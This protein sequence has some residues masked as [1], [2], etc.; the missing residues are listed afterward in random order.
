MPPLLRLEEPRERELVLRIELE[1]DRLDEVD[2]R[3]EPDER[4]L[5]DEREL[6][7]ELARDEARLLA[8]AL[9]ALL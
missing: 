2:E 7:D 5:L 6:P 1:E 9:T 3:E 4:E 8:L